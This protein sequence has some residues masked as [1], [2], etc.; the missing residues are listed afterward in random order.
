MFSD[1]VQRRL[2][3]PHGP[4]NNSMLFA[5][6]IA[7]NVNVIIFS[8]RLCVVVRIAAQADHSDWLLVIHTEILLSG[9]KPKNTYS[10]LGTICFRN[11][12]KRGHVMPVNPR[13]KH[14]DF[15]RKC[16]PYCQ[17]SG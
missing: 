9:L 11:P 3:R 7:I 17:Q 15:R 5:V 10:T 14:V 4:M 2:F 12:L 13:S 1:I 8:G 6:L 16:V